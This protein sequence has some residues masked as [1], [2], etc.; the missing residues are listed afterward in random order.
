MAT[1]KLQ[2]SIY[3]EFLT[4]S[5]LTEEDLANFSFAVKNLTQFKLLM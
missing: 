1:G 4:T 2:C 3:E 5:D